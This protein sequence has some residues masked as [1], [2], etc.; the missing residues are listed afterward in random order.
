MDDAMRILTK[1]ME[2]LQGDIRDVFHKITDLTK[3]IHDIKCQ[4]GKCVS[5]CDD[6]YAKIVDLTDDIRKY[7]DAQYVKIVDLSDSIRKVCNAE[8]ILKANFKDDVK[9]T[10]EDIT[11]DWIR[12]MKSRMSLMNVAMC[13][14][15]S[16][17][18]I[19][20]YILIDLLKK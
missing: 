17:A 20:G 12:K 9:K 15:S 4:R 3:E 13:L 18:G 14:L 7:C 19:F 1:Y 10:I 5:A 16:F 2:S 8:Y 11:E 6:R